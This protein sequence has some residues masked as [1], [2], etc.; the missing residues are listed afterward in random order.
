MEDNNIDYVL[1]VERDDLKPKKKSPLLYIIPCAVV[2]V[3]AVAVL[4]SFILPGTFT[5][6]WELTVNPEITQAT[7][8]EIEEADRVYYIFEKADK[9]GDGKWKVCF[10]GGVEHYEYE[11]LKE[12]GANKI[13][14]GSVNLD[15]KFKGSAILGNR[16]VVLTLPEQ[17]DETTGLTTQ[18]QEYVL[19]RAKNPK[20]EKQSYKRFEVD[21]KLVGEWI[22]NE[23]TLEYYMYEI[24]YTETVE[25]LDNGVFNI[26]YESEDLALDRYMY[27]A[28]TA[29]DGKLAFS[30]VTDEETQYTVSY[31]FDENGNLKFTDDETVDSIFADAFFSS[32]TYY[33]PDN[34]SEVETETSLTD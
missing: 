30:L 9:F 4:L 25:F 23:R 13:N 7:G 14:L 15:Y 34:V 2:L 11:L 24:P 5:G 33:T 19:E 32:V 12:D 29:N 22:T 10:D 17:I 26:H 6:V 31:E 8:D 21:E 27:Y 16:K 3:M 18:A 28:Y 20:Y 1:P